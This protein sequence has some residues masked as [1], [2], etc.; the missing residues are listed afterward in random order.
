MR[1]VHPHAS[2][3]HGAAIL[4]FDPSDGSS[5][6]EWGTRWPRVPFR[7]ARRFIPTRVGNTLLSAVQ[8]SNKAVHPHASGEHVLA[9]SPAAQGSGSSPREWGTRPQRLLCES[10]RRFIPTRVGN[11]GWQGWQRR[12]GPV[13]PHASGEHSSKRCDRMLLHG[14]SPRE[15]GTHQRSSEPSEKPRFIPT[16]VG[17]TGAH[18]GCQPV[19]PVHPHA[20]GEHSRMPVITLSRAG[21]S[22]R[23]WGTRRERRKGTGRLRF[24]PTRVGNT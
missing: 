23:E 14:S 22:P 13:H 19:R 9:G 21:S 11:T 16:R 1:T 18:A 10:Q 4:N 20:S 12:R 7:V 2:G 17:N 8:R 15:W 24:I 6:R 5:P 3:E